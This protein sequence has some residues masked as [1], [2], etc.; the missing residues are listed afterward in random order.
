[1]IDI[2]EKLCTIMQNERVSS[3]NALFFCLNN[4]KE[5]DNNV[6]VYESKPKQKPCRGL[7]YTGNNN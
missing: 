3:M 7:R 1:M 4:T 5:V 6:C 2:S